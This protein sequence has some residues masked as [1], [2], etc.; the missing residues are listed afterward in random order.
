MSK[1]TYLIAGGSSGIGLELKKKRS[2][3]G[4]RVV[5]LSRSGD[6]LA[7]LPHVS[8]LPKNILTDEPAEGELPDSLE[9]VAYC[10]GSINLKPFRSQKGVIQACKSS[11]K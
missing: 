11:K 9:G 10:P 6:S 2:A 7:G 3:P 4:K 8:F 5:V 1:K